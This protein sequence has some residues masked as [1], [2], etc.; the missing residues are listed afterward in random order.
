MLLI[1]KDLQPFVN[2]ICRKFNFG[3]AVRLGQ[4]AA[5]QGLQKLP[6]KLPGSQ[7]PHAGLSSGLLHRLV[8][9]DHHH[10]LRI[11]DPPQPLLNKMVGRL[12]LRRKL[13]GQPTLLFGFW[14]M[15]PRPGVKNNGETMA[16]AG[17]IAA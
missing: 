17:A 10:F 2:F 14:Q 15:I 4:G 16:G 9:T 7:P 12:A 8:G 5:G 11:F 6:G 3:P 1:I 13:D